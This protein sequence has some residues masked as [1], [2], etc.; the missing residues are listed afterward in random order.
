MIKKYLQYIKESDD[1]NT[2]IGKGDWISYKLNDEEVWGEILNI[3]TTFR[4]YD[5][6]ETDY[7]VSDLTNNKTHLI[8]PKNIIRKLTDMEISSIKY[9]L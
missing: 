3:R 8:I 2:S 7:I 1:I 9:N 6:I 5:D 4:A